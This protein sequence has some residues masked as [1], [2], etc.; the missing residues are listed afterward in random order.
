MSARDWYVAACLLPILSAWLQSDAQSAAHMDAGNS[1]QAGSSAQ[2]TG[3]ARDLRMG[4]WDHMQI[5][6][7]KPLPEDQLV[8]R[9]YL[10]L[11]YTDT[12]FDLM[13]RDSAGKFFFISNAVQKLDGKPGL[14]ARP[15]IPLLRASPKG[16]VPEERTRLWG[17]PATQELTP[18]NKILYTVHSGDAREQ[19]RFN[20][21]DLEW[22]SSDGNVHLSGAITSPAMQFLLPWREPGGNTNLMYY[23]AQFYKVDGTFD[24][25]PVNG[26]TMVEHTW[27][28]RSYADTWWVH[29]RVGYVALWNTT[30][31]D[32]VTDM[33]YLYCGEFG[34]RGAVIANSKGERLLETIEVNAERAGSHRV[35]FT[36]VKGPRWE[37]I[38]DPTAVVEAYKGSTT[39]LGF[40]TVRRVHETRKV[41]R[42]AALY[43]QSNLASK[44]VCKPRLLGQAD[45]TVR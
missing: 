13:L 16:L 28:D 22:Q 19:I 37:F 18:D 35:V 2:I 41:I 9:Q 36:F 4:E 43:L 39:T 20:D 23:T 38:V 30:Y 15:W 44:Q 10:G 34:A 26:Y 12:W 1:G 11:R 8:T 33:G 29:N 14:S 7:F 3:Y 21:Q 25:R 40:G 45:A 32:G 24:G 31:S 27:G 42:S 6:L 5:G 17:G